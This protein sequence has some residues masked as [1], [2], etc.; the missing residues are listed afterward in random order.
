MEYFPLGD[1][2]NYLESSKNCPHSRLSE[3]EVR[4]I[5]TQLLDALSM[6]HEQRFSH[7]DLKPAVRAL[8]EVWQE[9]IG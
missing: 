8:S 2:R 1:L 3:D 6:M 7:R 5:T 4:E 9:Q